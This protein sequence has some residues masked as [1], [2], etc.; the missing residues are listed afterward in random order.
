VRHRLRSAICI[1]VVALAGVIAVGSGCSNQWEG[2]RCTAISNDP[3]PSTNGTQDCQD[4][5]VCISAINIQATG[6][7]D[8]CC[9]ANLAS[10]TVEACMMGTLAGGNPTD[11][12]DA[13][14]VESGTDA[15]DA[16]STPDGKEEDATDKD[17]K[18]GDAKTEDA[19]KADAE[20]DA[21]KAAD[22]ETDADK[23]STADSSSD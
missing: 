15:A 20:K 14:F 21:G 8:R 18:A 10:A 7:Y 19:E 4:G 12:R 13:A 9:P 11:G 22:A 6:D 5:L 23:D 17:V 16:K 2:E 1:A 3:N